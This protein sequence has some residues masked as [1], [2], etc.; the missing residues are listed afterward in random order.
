MQANNE[1]PYYNLKAVVQQTGL[2]PDTLRAWERRYGLPKP[3]RSG[4]G[5]RL[6]TRHDIE[7]LKWL[8]ARQEE[9][10]SIA[11]AVDLW[12]KMEADGRDPLAAAGPGV[13]AAGQSRATP[14]LGVT[15]AQLREEW[16]A[17][18]LTYDE[19]RSEQ[20]L[21]QAF[22]LYPVETVGLE[23]LQAAVSQIGDGWYR[24]EV[25]VQQEHFCSA[26]ALRRLN[27]L[28]LATPP[29]TRR[30]TILTTCPPQEQHVFSLLLLTLFLRRRGLNVVYLGANVPVE[31]LETTVG[32]INPHLVVMTAQ[33]LQGAA[34]MVEAA[35]LLEREGVML[36]F[37]G[38]VFN[39]I[40]S[41]RSRVPGHFLGERLDEASEAVEALLMAPRPLPETASIPEAYRSAR[42]HFRERLGLIETDLGPA[43]GSSGLDP[44][45]KAMANRELANNISA[46]LA[47][48]DMNYLSMDVEWLKGLLGNYQLPTELLHDYLV[49]YGEAAG[50]NLDRR[51][52]LVT[53]WL[54]AV[55]RHNGSG[56]EG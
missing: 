53:E 52:A 28:L 15:L 36:A 24:G 55:V 21:A 6:Y 25:T 33:H 23:L 20:A 34:S 16:M 41:L 44:A 31:R 38:L 29:P 5:H 48:G 3:Q 43:I 54:Q 56:R 49:S 27:A 12:R 4:G 18:C 39:L 42:E 11:R 45:Y 26:L 13:V 7:T 37:G 30:G 9:G 17:A 47:L 8:A 19:Q 50:R 51:G 46:A 1:G 35:Q 2:K 10:L 22:A 32:A 40:P 14:T